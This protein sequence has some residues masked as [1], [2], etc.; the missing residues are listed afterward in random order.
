M[1]L[2]LDF[3]Y[4]ID[5][6][7]DYVNYYRSE[8]PMDAGSMPAPTATGITGNT[9]T[10]T[11]ATKGKYYYVRFSSVRSGVEKISAEIKILAGVL[12]TPA[13]LSISAK[14]W[15]DAES[16][17]V[18]ASNRISQLS[19][20]TGNNN[21]FVQ[22]TNGNKPLKSGLDIVFDG[23]DDYM[24]SSN[25]VSISKNV[26]KLWTFVV[27]KRTDTDLNTKCLFRFV[28]GTT[29]STAGRYA[30]YAGTSVSTNLG[31]GTRR[32]DS[33]VISTLY[34]TTDK[35]NVYTIACFY[36]DYADATGYIYADTVEYKNTSMGSAGSTSNTDSGNPAYLGAE[37]VTAGYFKGSIATMITGNTNLSLNDRQK[38]E[39]WAA[40]KYGLLAN[41]PAGHPYK[42]L[43]PT[44]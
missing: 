27:F 17:T 14:I 19:D 18:D 29:S 40:H 43:V 16:A 26:N 37:R 5:G 10:D 20:K 21:H 22:S 7:Y 44:V 24:T 23:V 41:L 35:L 42:I 30:C 11:T 12:W 38:L 31:L 28:T 9:Y 3:S 25:A 34:N 13:N 6:F 2:S 32:L 1:A 8:T 36:Q 15:L 39:G 4:A 33:D